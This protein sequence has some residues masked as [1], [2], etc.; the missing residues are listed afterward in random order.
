[1]TASSAAMLPVSRVITIRCLTDQQR[2][3]ELAALAR[4]VIAG[5]ISPALAEA[6]LSAFSHGSMHGRALGRAFRGYLDAVRLETAIGDGAAALAG[7]C[8]ELE[9]VDR[10]NQALRNA[11][12]A[13]ARA[14]AVL[15][16]G[17]R[18]GADA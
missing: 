10:Q 6:G 7:T 2:G 1:M 18:Y 11:G 8:P 3:A 12:E 9:G 5:T 15:V 13:A 4:L 17:G 16:H 14:L